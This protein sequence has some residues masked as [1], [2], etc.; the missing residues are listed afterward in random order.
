MKKLFACIWIGLQLIAY[1]DTFSS[2]VDDVYRRY[3]Q[4]Q[5]DWCDELLGKVKRIVADQGGEVS[6][7]ELQK[8]GVDVD[9]LDIMATEYCRKHSDAY[10][11]TI[12]PTMSYNW[13][14]RIYDIL[15]A[16]CITVAYH[17]KF[18]LKNRGPLALIQS[19]PEKVPH[20]S[21]DFHRYF[22]P[23]KK[24]YPMMCF[25]VRA[26]ELDNVIAAKK[27]LRGIVKL[28]PY[29]MHFN[30]THEQCV[31]LA[32]KFL[33]NNSLHFLNHHK[34]Q[35]FS[36]FNKLV[37]I[38]EK[39][40]EEQG[41][42]PD[43]VCVDGSSVLSVYGIRDSAMDFDFIC[44][45]QGNFGNI[46]P[47]DHHNQAW[48]ALGLRIEDVI[49][50]PKNFFYYKNLKFASIEVLKKFKTKQGREKDIK[51]VANLEAIVHG[52]EKLGPARNWLEKT[53]LPKLQG[54]ILYVG[55]G[56]YTTHYHK[57]T[58]TPELFETIDFAIDKAKFGAPHHHVGEFMTF[59]PDYP[60][61]HICL[62]GVMGHP[63][64]VGT[65]IYS[66]TEDETIIEAFEHAHQ[67]LKVGGTLQLGPNHK[68]VPQQN[69]AFWKE[70]FSISL[71]DK[72]EILFQ[73]VGSDNMIWWGRKLSD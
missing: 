63:Q 46:W 14:K 35:T 72:Y 50:N 36:N 3:H 23:A 27:K 49:Y 19:I 53:Y 25:V 37:P 24:E 26:K 57:L 16:H 20:I 42:S 29:C 13:E 47:L 6:F 40:I 22:D 66:M 34:E 67:L 15:E 70:R 12:W 45:K 59:N 9:H 18:V 43:D 61:D 71:F 7:L 8:G 10:I 38:Y 65:S 48:D 32:Y 4:K 17:K 54:R 1:D 56:S 51:D 69:E 44:T 62:F 31:E 58:K 68:T 2:L 33:N 30:D 5:N 55:V 21:K 39:F 11:A 41:I 52:Y 64:D 28:D 60:F 73:G